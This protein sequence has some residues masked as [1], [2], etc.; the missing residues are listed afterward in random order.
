MKLSSLLSIYSFRFLFFYFLTFLLFY[1]MMKGIRKWAA[2]WLLVSSSDE[3]GAKELTE[4]C[5]GMGARRI[6]SRD[7]QIS[8]PGKKVP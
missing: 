1:E 2:V 6:F 5:W 8:C 3:T 4:I 7:G